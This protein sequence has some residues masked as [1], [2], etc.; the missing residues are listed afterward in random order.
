MHLYIQVHEYVSLDEHK[1]VH[2][3]IKVVG[4]LP[5]N[6]LHTFPYWGFARRVH[7]P[8]QRLNMLGTSFP[9]SRTVSTWKCN[10]ILA[11]RIEQKSGKALGKFSFPLEGNTWGEFASFGCGQWYVV[12]KSGTA[13]LVPWSNWE[14]SPRAEDGRAKQL[15]RATE[16]TSYETPHLWIS[17]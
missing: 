3:R 6:L 13:V 16:L 10:P 4:H 5:S 11:N 7:F 9:V 17:H 2:E 8:L 1:E 15:C 14:K 12:Y